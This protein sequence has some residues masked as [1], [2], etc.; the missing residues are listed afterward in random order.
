MLEAPQNR[1]FSVYQELKTLAAILVHRGW[2][3]AFCWI[4][5]FIP[6]W[7]YIIAP[8]EGI[9]LDLMQV[10]AFATIILG[11]FITRSFEKRQG[12]A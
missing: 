2:R 7:A 6:A 4:G 8:R 3:P 12:I 5:V 10:N 1:A 9:H 11:A